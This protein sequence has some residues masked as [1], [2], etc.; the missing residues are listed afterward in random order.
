MISLE[1]PTDPLKERVRKTYEKMHA[2][3]TVEF[4]KSRIKEGCDS[5]KAKMDY[6][7]IV[8]IK[9]NDLVDE[10]DPDTSLPK[11]RSGFSK[12]QNLSERK[13]PDMDWYALDRR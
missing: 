13:H 2:N 1:D 8:L 11:Y 7:G 3:Q 9:L 4:V 10:S 6:K 12:L 5:T